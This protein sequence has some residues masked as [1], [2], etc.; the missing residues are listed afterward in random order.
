MEGTVYFPQCSFADIAQE[1][2]VFDV[3]EFCRWRVGWSHALHLLLPHLKL[4]I[5]LFVSH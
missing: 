3:F 1:L 2:K 5:Y 4:L